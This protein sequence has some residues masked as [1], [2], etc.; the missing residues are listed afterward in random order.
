[1]AAAAGLHAVSTDEGHVQGYKTGRDTA[2]LRWVETVRTSGVG[3]ACPSLFAAVGCGWAFA[4]ES[5]GR[6]SGEACMRLPGRLCKLVGKVQAIGGNAGY[7]TSDRPSGHIRYSADR[8]RRIAA[9]PYTPNGS[10]AEPHIRDIKAAMSDGGLDSVGAISGALKWRFDSGLIGPARFY[11][12]AT[13]D[14]PR[15]SPR[16]AAGIRKRL[17]PGE[18]LAHVQ[19]GMP[20]KE[21]TVPA[22]EEVRAKEDETPLR[23][24]AQRCPQC[25]PTQTLRP[26]FLRGFPRYCLRNRTAGPARDACRAWRLRCGMTICVAICFLQLFFRPQLPAIPNAFL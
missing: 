11:D 24:N 22:I 21:V 15:I 19:R 17:G 14:P 2:G 9:L 16:K 7:H 1:M 18:H 4:T 10:A 5:P 13:A 26:A 20:G 8:L 6:A 25:W 3:R 12:C 23:K